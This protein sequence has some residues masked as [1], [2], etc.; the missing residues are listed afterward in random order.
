M[1]QVTIAMGAMSKPLA[2]QLKDFN[3]AEK[4]LVRLQKIADSI[5]Q[6]V[7][8]NYIPQSQADRCRKKMMK[9]IQVAID[10]RNAEL[11]GV[12]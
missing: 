1:E 4:T 10:K 6:L 8:L 12:A 3:L 11:A 9:E 5:T 2:E 7:N